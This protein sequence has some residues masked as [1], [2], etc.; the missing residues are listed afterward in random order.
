MVLLGADQQMYKIK[1]L[2]AK[3]HICSLGMKNETDKRKHMF[4]IIPLAKEHH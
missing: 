2:L 4:D 1:K 3:S